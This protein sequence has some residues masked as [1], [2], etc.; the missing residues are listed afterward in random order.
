M[1][2]IMIHARVK[3]DLLDEFLEM[4]SLLTRETQGKRKGCINYSF[5]QRQDEPTEFV[6]FEQWQ[7]QAALDEH[8]HQLTILLGPPKAGELLPDKL[9]YMY[10][11]ATPCFYN[12]I[13]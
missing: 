1:L 8:I 7:N 13:Q 4:A 2:T 12:V 11:S 10:E 9:I 5:N 3:L 6:I